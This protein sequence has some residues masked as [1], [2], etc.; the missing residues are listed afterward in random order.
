MP[1]ILKEA[2]L[3]NPD[4]AAYLP[5]RQ[6][7]LQID[8]LISL[9]PGICASAEIKVT[10][11]NGAYPPMLLIEAMAQLGGIAAGQEGA[12]SGVLAAIESSRLPASVAAGVRLLAAARIIKSFG[13]LHLVEGQVYDEDE[14]IIASA[15]LTLAIA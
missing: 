1:L 3:F 12:S 9:E 14:K 13:T 15:R 10:A 6:P 5:H 2:L 7:F 8:R 4:P 11:G